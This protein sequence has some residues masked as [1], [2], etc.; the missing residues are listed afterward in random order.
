MALVILPVVDI[1]LAHSDIDA[2]A[3]LE[4]AIAHLRAA[5]ADESGSGAVPNSS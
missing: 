1:G 2:L 4:D 5:L 3:D